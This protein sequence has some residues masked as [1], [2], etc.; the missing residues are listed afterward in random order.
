MAENKSIEKVEVSKKSQ[1]IN[2]T[3]SK[4]E[5][6]QKQNEIVT[7]EIVTVEVIRFEPRE[8]DSFAE[9][10]D[11]STPIQRSDIN[12]TKNEQTS[13]SRYKDYAKERRMA[14]KLVRNKKDKQRLLKKRIN[15]S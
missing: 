4:E 12:E 15:L 3:P 7:N 5:R 13:N 9:N 8:K 14:K 10:I 11:K 1:S 6:I 2:Q